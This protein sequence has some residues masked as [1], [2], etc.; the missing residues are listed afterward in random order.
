MNTIKIEQRTREDIIILD[1]MGEIDLHNSR[2]IRDQVARLIQFGSKM[3]VINLARVSSIDSSGIG[4]LLAG[5][6]MLHETQGQ[7]RLINLPPTVLK[8][9]ELT[10]VGPAI[11]NICE[12]ESDAIETLKQYA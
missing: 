10:N 6:S 12:S 3:I 8:V 1:I 9:M 11:F 4:S 5:S 2:T 7:L